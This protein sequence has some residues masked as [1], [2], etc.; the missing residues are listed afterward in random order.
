[1]RDTSTATIEALENLDVYI[2]RTVLIKIAY[3]LLGILFLVKFL[4]IPKII[5]IAI[6]LMILYALI[7][8]FLVHRYKIQ[9][10]SIINTLFLLILL[11]LL[12]ITVIINFLGITLYI[13]YSFYLVLGYMTLPRSKAIYLTIW[14]VILY[15]GLASF[16]YFKISQPLQLFSPEEVTP[17][18]LAY[19]FIA[20]S[21]FLVTL[22]FLSI[23][24]YDFYKLIENRIITLRKTQLG[25]TEEKRSLEL[26]IQ[27][28]KKELKEQKEGLAEKVKIR[29]K[30][31]EMENKKIEERIEE[32]EKFRQ[33]AL[34]RE[35]KIKEL[36]N[37]MEKLK[38]KL[39]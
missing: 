37:E 6:F 16:Q 20:T 17:H 18:N 11:D 26:K 2:K 8:F 28:R 35:I 29:K 15:L 14:V 19:A 36:K 38:R 5:F 31:L 32:L 7:L 27:T 13:I 12:L 39:K 9:A 23:R 34:G 22:L 4:Y 33:L 30:E 10:E 24:C 1:M 3:F 25:L 21:F